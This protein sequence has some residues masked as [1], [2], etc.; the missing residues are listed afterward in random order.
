MSPPLAPREAPLSPP[1]APR[2]APPAP[3]AGQAAWHKGALREKILE[4]FDKDGDGKLSPEGG[5]SPATTT[6]GISRE[7]GVVAGGA[8]REGGGGR[9]GGGPARSPRRGQ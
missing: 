9:A 5:A 8:R 4:K 1:L 2:E 6:M 3:G 7:L